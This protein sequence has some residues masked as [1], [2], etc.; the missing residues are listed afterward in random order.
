VSTAGSWVRR[1]EKELCSITGAD[2]AIAVCN[3]TIALRLALHLVGL[4]TDDEVLV[5]PLSYVAKVNCLTDLG[6]VPDFVDVDASD[7]GLSANAQTDQLKKVAERRDGHLFNRKTGR[8]I[9]LQC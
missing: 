5:P 1:F 4:I 9:S 8:H 7:L 3:S 6:A 2:H